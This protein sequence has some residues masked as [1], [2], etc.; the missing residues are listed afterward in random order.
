MRRPVPL[1]LLTALA[2]QPAT[3]QETIT[4]E[5]VFKQVTTELSDAI[6]LE[7]GSESTLT[8]DYFISGSGKIVGLQI[9][10]SNGMRTGFCTPICFTRDGPPKKTICTVPDGCPGVPGEGGGGSP[11]LTTGPLL[12]EITSKPS[13]NATDLGVDI[14]VQQFGLD[15]VRD[16]PTIVTHV[17]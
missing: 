2:M 12:L 10:A 7:D 5:E 14:Q 9:A 8:L 17:K 6:V 13:L 16:F 15:Q 1:V 3:A 4:S 11:V